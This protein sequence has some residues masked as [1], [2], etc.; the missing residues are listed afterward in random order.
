MLYALC[1]MPASYLKCSKQSAAFPP[2]RLLVLNPI[3]TLQSRLPIDLF[4]LLFFFLFLRAGAHPFGN[5]FWLN[6]F[7]GCCWEGKGPRSR[8]RRHERICCD[9]DQ[10]AKNTMPLCRAVEEMAR[11]MDMEMIRR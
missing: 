1:S 5:G 2:M 7:N 8:R 10:T 11:E 9:V 3:R 6:N 4:F